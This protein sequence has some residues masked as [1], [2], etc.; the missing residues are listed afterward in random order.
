MED[1]TTSQAAGEDGR[2]V[3]ERDVDLDSLVCPRETVL[4]PRAQRSG[5][6]FVAQALRR[7]ACKAR[8]RIQARAID[9]AI[10]TGRVMSAHTKAKVYE[11]CERSDGIFDTAVANVEA[12][13]KKS[14]ADNTNSQ[15]IQVREK[16]DNVIPK[17]RWS[18]TGKLSVYMDPLLCRLCLRARKTDPMMLKIL[19]PLLHFLVMIISIILR[20]AWTQD[21]EIHVPRP[22][23]LTFL[24][25]CVVA[26]L[27][28]SQVICAIVLAH[29]G[30][31][32]RHYFLGPPAH[33]AKR[34]KIW[35]GRFSAVVV[36]M[37]LVYISVIFF[38]VAADTID[39]L[40]LLGTNLPNMVF[41]GLHFAFAF[42]IL[43]PRLIDLQHN[44][45]MLY[46]LLENLL[47]QETS[48]VGAFHEALDAV[49]KVVA[50]IRVFGWDF[51]LYISITIAVPW[52]FGV[53]SI[54]FM[55]DTF[56]AHARGAHEST[57]YPDPDQEKVFLAQAGALV[58][59]FFLT[60]L[61]LMFLV[62]NVAQQ[63]HY[64][65]RLLDYNLKSSQHIQSAEKYRCIT[66]IRHLVTTRGSLRLYG[67]QVTRPKVVG[68]LRYAFKFFSLYIG[69]MLFIRER[70]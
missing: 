33:L 15:N 58:I 18:R 51:Q 35:L 27:W 45:K 1:T 10:N 46:V 8:E 56:S 69:L 9:F 57:S 2:L 50:V 25:Y 64:L 41:L 26:L 13:A 7:K 4:Q 55:V 17:I 5:S 68:I 61:L 37:L 36:V 48:A 3:S 29:R 52:S 67:M 62:S 70:V 47:E 19:L 21:D 53:G 34:T 20:T 66:E 6:S 54:L 24:W 44:T 28:L 11:V 12:A 38:A 23:P 65:T 49:K 32:D 22:N 60:G 14:S 31:F 42:G 63:N 59:F 30:V 39:M 16:A 43:R 40:W